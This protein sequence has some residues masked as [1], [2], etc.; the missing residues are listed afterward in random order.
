MTHGQLLLNI[1]LC[2]LVNKFCK[3]DVKSLKTAL[4]DF[5]D[6]DTVIIE[7]KVTANEISNQIKSNLV[8]SK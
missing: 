3:V 1:V 6:V 2:F 7:C 4:F 8:L 5:C